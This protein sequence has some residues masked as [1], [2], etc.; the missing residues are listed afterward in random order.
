MTITTLV[1]LGL[2]MTNGADRALA[3]VGTAPFQQIRDGSARDHRS[4]LW[5]LSTD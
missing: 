1:D 2:A 3:P 4:A 5:L